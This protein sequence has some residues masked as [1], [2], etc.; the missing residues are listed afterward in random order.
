MTTDTS[1][2]SATVKELVKTN[3]PKAY[4]ANKSGL[5]ASTIRRLSKWHGEPY[6][7]Q[8]KTVEFALRAM[9]K[10]LEITDA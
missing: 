3:L 4:I 10:K 6:R 8:L 5:S 1:I 7:P 9:G 2:I